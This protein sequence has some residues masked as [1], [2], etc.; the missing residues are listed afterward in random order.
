MSE[1]L[2][3]NTAMINAEIKKTPQLFQ[4]VKNSNEIMENK[5]PN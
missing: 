4:N 1:F 2:S 5:T 3:V